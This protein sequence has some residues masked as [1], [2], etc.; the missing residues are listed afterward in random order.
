MCVADV[1]GLKCFVDLFVCEFKEMVLALHGCDFRLCF[2][3]FCELLLY[4]GN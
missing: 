3:L 4:F 1:S 2:W